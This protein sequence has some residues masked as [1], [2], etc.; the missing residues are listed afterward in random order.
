MHEVVQLLDSARSAARDRSV[1]SRH[2][3]VGGRVVV[4]HRAE[5]NYLPISCVSCG[6]RRTVHSARLRTY[7]ELEA[8]KALA[9]AQMAS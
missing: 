9:E 4:D 2:D 5:E 1:V 3:V 7:E 8:R 6:C